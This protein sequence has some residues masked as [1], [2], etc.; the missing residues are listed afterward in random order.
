MTIRHPVYGVLFCWALLT[1]YAVYDQLIRNP[2][3]MEEKF[4]DDRMWFAN[5]PG[6]SNQSVFQRY[7]FIK[8]NRGNYFSFVDGSRSRWMT[9]L[10]DWR[11]NHNVLRMSFD[12]KGEKVSTTFSIEDCSVGMFDLRLII[13]RDP[14]N[15]FK[16]T[17]YYSR[18][19]GMVTENPET[20]STYKSD[21][22]R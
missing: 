4:L 16:E 7:W 13:H 5:H 19:D 22:Y 1:A 17:V 20:P 14:R 10:G 6:A 21:I 2:P 11:S 18:K 12:H 8:Y 9:W 15:D 3:S